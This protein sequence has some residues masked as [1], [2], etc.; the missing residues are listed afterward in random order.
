MRLNLRFGSSPLSFFSDVG[1]PSFS[2]SSVEA[3]GFFNLFTNAW[4]KPLALALKAP[5]V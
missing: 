2:T 4:A 5:L 3:T 1:L